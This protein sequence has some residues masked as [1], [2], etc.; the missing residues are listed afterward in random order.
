MNT[1]FRCYDNVRIA[2]LH[3]RRRLTH[4]MFVVEELARGNDQDPM[5]LSED[6]DIVSTVVVM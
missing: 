6:G 4:D 5:Q 1:M 3:R 2:T